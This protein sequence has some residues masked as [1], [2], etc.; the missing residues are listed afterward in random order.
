MPIVQHDQDL[1]RPISV[2]M[3]ANII[4]VRQYRINLPGEFQEKNG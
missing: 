2:I 3:P 4:E 1:A